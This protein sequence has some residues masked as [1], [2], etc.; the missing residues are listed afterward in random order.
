MQVEYLSVAATENDESKSLTG[1]FPV[2]ELDDGETRLSESLSIARYLSQDKLG[3]YGPDRAQKAMID[4]WLDIINL[5][6]A[7]H[8]YN[9]VQ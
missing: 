2:L 7:P 4:Q 1:S 3:F 8:A 9:L 6:V 5:K